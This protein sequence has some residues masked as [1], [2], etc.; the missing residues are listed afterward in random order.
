MRLSYD[1]EGRESISQSWSNAGQARQT[2]LILE[3]GEGYGLFHEL[4]REAVEV[5]DGVSCFSDHNNS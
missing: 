5:N 2:A 4:C 1:I 3:E